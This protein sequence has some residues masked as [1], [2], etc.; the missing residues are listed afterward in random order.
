MQHPKPWLQERPEINSSI[1]GSVTKKENINILATQAKELLTTK[2]RMHLHV[3]T[4][5]SIQDDGATGSAAVIPDFKLSRTAKLNSGVSIFTAEMHAIQMA[6]HALLDLPSPPTQAVILS[7]S[8]SALQALERK[9]TGNRKE[10]AHEIHH[11]FHQIITRGTELTL[12]WIPSHTGIRGN[13]TADGAAK[14]AA[15]QGRP[16]DLRFSPSEICGQLNR[17]CTQRN[18]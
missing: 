13:D 6:C 11:L 1:P 8:R 2:Y 12:Q 10:L 14:A 17:V 15:T 5:G 3:Y 7:D 9:T 18:D 16:I 4:D